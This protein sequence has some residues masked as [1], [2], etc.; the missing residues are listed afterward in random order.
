MK[1]Q[2]GAQ[3]GKGSNRRDEE[4]DGYVGPDR[5]AGGHYATTNA[6]SFRFPR[7]SDE[8]IEKPIEFRVTATELRSYTVLFDEHHRIFGW[9]SKSDMYR[10]FMK[11]GLADAVKT[12]TRPDPELLEMVQQEEE[13]LKTAKRLLRHEHAENMIRT[14][15]E[16]I[17]GLVDR[18]D[19]VSV[20][21]VLSDMKRM[22]KGV[23]DPVL[24]ASLEKEFEQKWRDMDANL[25]RLASLNPGSFEDD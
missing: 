9:K 14:V 11:T 1:Q 25:N 10:D 13:V 7:T 18:H 23:R 22:I 20:R 2:Q 21:I 4:R 16:N 8:P 12:L 17:R 5:D 3:M 19:Y 6:G 15:E 24:R